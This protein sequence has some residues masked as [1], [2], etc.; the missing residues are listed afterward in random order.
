MAVFETV[1]Y[2]PLINNFIQVSR[3]EDES[4][5]QKRY[6][7]LRLIIDYI[8]ASLR[9]GEASTSSLVGIVIVKHSGSCGLS[10]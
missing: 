2:Q 3:T 6:K 9:P 4:G 1:A 5:G 8:R 7:K 10:M